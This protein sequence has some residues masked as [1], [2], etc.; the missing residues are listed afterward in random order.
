MVSQQLKYTVLFQQSYH[1][2]S[3][4]VLSSVLLLFILLLLLLLGEEEMAI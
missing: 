2:Y 3:E 4:M 1:P